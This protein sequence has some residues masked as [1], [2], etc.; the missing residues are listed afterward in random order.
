MQ[1]VAMLT[2]LVLY[3]GSAW[4]LLRL[5]LAHWRYHKALALPKGSDQDSELASAKARFQLISVSHPL[6]IWPM[7]TAS[8]IKI[9]L[10]ISTPAG[11]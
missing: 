5:G 11:G 3:V 8:L 10:I 2:D 1:T 9:V 6:V 4:L 7:L